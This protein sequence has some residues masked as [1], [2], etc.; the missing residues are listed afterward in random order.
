M[1]KKPESEAN[2]RPRLFSLCAAPILQMIRCIENRFKGKVN[3]QNGCFIH[4]EAC[5]TEGGMDDAPQ[6]LYCAVLSRKIGQL[7]PFQCKVTSEFQGRK[8]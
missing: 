3:I 2:L 4:G 7:S 6:R 1:S 8:S 5:Q